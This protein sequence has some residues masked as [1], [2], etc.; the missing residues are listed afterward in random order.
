MKP[1]NFIT[2]KTSPAVA[3]RAALEGK[4]IELGVDAVRQSLESYLV[5]KY[6]QSY[7]FKEVGKVF[8]THSQMLYALAE[9]VKQV[10]LKQHDNLKLEKSVNQTRQE[11]WTFS[12]ME[13]AGYPFLKW[14]EHCDKPFYMQYMTSRTLYRVVKLV[15]DAWQVPFLKAKYFSPS[16]GKYVILSK[17]R[18]A[19]LA[20]HSMEETLKTL[21]TPFL[22]LNSVNG[23]LYY[24]IGENSRAY[25]GITEGNHYQDLKDLTG[26]K[27]RP[28]NLD[29]SRLPAHSPACW[30]KLLP[31]IKVTETPP[32]AAALEEKVQ[33]APT[34]P[35]SHASRIYQP[36]PENI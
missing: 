11:E 13:Q 27:V 2:I 8:Q 9:A 17:F 28:H 6:Q 33:A 23:T 26:Y 34:S 29:A 16:Y 1:E 35:A 31:L 30:E 24:I 32:Q 25:F 18:E 15:G 22:Y 36:P 3:E 5:E 12:I 4:E 19:F 20:T 21:G 7:P 10:M 14:M